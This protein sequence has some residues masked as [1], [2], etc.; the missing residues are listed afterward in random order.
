MDI[1]G[2][3]GNDLV[4]SYPHFEKIMNCG[5]GCNFGSFSCA[6]ADLTDDEQGVLISFIGQIQFAKRQPY[7]V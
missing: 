3:Q 5:I 7:Q 1:T 6:V 2:N 4:G